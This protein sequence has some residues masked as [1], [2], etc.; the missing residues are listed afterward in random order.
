MRSE[1]EDSNGVKQCNAQKECKDP[2][3]NNLYERGVNGVD[4]EVLSKEQNDVILGEASSSN[5]FAKESDMGT[6]SDNDKHASYAQSMN[7]GLNDD[8]NKLFTIP[9]SVNRNGK[10]VVLFDEELVREGCEKWKLTVC[11]YFVGCK[12]HI[13]V[14]K[15]NIRRMWTRL[16]RSIIMDHM[17]T[18]M[19]KEGFG[20]LGYARVLVEVDAGKEYLEKVEINYVD[21][22]VSSDEEDIIEEF[23]EASDLVANEIRDAYKIE[24]KLLQQ[25]AKVKWLNEGDKNTAYF[26]GIL[27]SRRRKSIVEFINDDNGIRYEGD[28]INEQFVKHFEKFLGKVDHVKS[29]DESNF[30]NTL[31]SAKANNMVCDVFDKEI[32]E[33][34]FEI[35]SNKASGPDGF[36][37][38][39][40]K[41][42][43]SIVGDEVCLAINEFFKNGKLLGEINSTLIAFIPKT[44]TPSKVSEFR[45]IACCYVI[46]KCISK[47]L[48]NRIK[49]GLEKVVHIN[50]SAFIP[51]RHIQDNI[52]IAQ[53]LLRVS[54]LTEW[55]SSVVAD[56]IHQRIDGFSFVTL[57]KKMHFMLSSMSVVYVLTTSMLEEGGENPTVEQVR[58]RVKWD[59]DDYVCRGLILNVVNMVEHNNSSMYNDNKGKHKHHDTRANPNKKPKVTCW[60][61][62]KLR[63]LKM[64]CKAGN[65]GNRANESSTKGSE[66]GSLNP[67]KGQNRCWFK[68]YESLN[69]GSILHIRNEST[70]LVHG[71]GY[72]DLRLNIVSDNI[73]YAFMSTSKLND[74]ILWRARLG[75]VHFKRMQDMSKD[76]LIPS[77]NIDTEKCTDMSKVDKV[78][79]KR[80]KPG[81]KSERAQ[82]IEAEGV[83]IFYGPTQ[84]HL[85]GQIKF[86]APPPE[87][88]VRFSRNPESLIR[89]RNLGEPSSPFDF[90]EVMNNNN[91]KEPPPQ[92]NNGPPPMVRPNGQD[93]RMLED[94]CQPSINGRGGPISPIPIQAMDFGLCHHMI[95]QVQNTCQFHRLPGDDANRDIDKLLEIAQHMKQNGVS[96]DALRLSPFPYS[97]THHAIAWYDRLPRNS[98]HSFDDMMR[99]FLSKYFPPFMVT[100]LRN[101]ITKFEQKTY[102][103]LFEAWERYKLS[104]DR[105]PNHNMLLVTQTDTFYNGLTL[106][107]RDTINA[108]AGG[109]FM[110]KTPE[111]CYELIENMTAHHNH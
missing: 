74:S 70:A 38:E 10:E 12:M 29:V 84:A 96:D 68:T 106:N 13:N 14:L 5:E 91:N 6:S 19:C 55:Y 15:Y 21:G 58:R 1:E 31:D 37:S 92:N 85:M 25:Q 50:Q 30:K 78:K 23:N 2:D 32:K 98:I 75:H 86:L 67:L 20:R 71:R 102:E 97:L 105:C 79:A 82:K 57:L 18:E 101:E 4:D 83:P 110:P 34:I 16:G 33:A 46:Y 49:S 108:A 60:K 45:P 51:R 107:H 73:G 40:F 76:G 69:D 87:R 56:N 53:E 95:Q 47:I 52:L 35:D 100:K 8:G 66:D 93:P 36:T 62:W 65:V 27:K 54:S 103:S 11:G 39:F 88:G 48:T 43:W 109:T 24:M 94:L 111:E 26:H 41:R 77:I 81:T 44:S 99:K 59:N 17:T 42:A 3:Q 28:V 61:C 80:T 7:K 9:T 64:D 22:D 90:E 63:H 72:V 104:I 89:R